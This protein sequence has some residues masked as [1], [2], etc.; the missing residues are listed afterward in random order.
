[1]VIS[2]DVALVILTCSLAANIAALC[3]A[4]YTVFSNNYNPNN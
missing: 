4:L 2:T 3:G 1:M